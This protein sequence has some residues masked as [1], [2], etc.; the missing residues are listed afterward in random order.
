MRHP[1]PLLFVAVG[2]AGCSRNPTLEISG[3]FFP[4][5]MLCIGIGLILSLV[6]KRF[7]LA[8]R[9]DAHLT[10]PL[11]VYGALML[12]ITLLAWLLLYL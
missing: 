12:N 7:F 6:A 9:I 10:P 2:L 1:L 8:T 3:S 5:W 11:L 4:A